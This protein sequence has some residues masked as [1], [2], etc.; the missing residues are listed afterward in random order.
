MTKLLSD[1]RMDVETGTSLSA[2][3]RKL[4]PCFDNLYRNLV[5]R[6]PPVS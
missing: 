5:R 4:R 3:F 1:I 2:A 6:R